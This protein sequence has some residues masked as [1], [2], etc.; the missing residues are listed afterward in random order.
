MCAHYPGARVFVAAPGVGQPLTQRT[1][2]R[3]TPQVI[4]YPPRGGLADGVSQVKITFG[5]R[6]PYLD[7]L[8]RKFATSEDATIT[9]LFDGDEGGGDGG[10]GDGGDGGDG[11]GGDGGDGEEEEEEEEEGSED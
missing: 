6:L 11:D 10:D 7:G 5:I 9:L 8:E 3:R 1:A 2:S 4:W